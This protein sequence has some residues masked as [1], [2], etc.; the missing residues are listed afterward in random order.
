MPRRIL[1]VIDSDSYAKWGASLLA[2]LGP[3]WAVELVTVASRLAASDAQLAFALAGTGFRP[4]AAPRASLQQIVDRLSLEGHDAVFVSTSGA[5]AEAVITEIT[6]RVKPR[7]VIMTGLPG[8]S[9]PAKYKGLFRRAQADLFVLHSH[10]EIREY[11]ELS[12]RRGI[13]H[14]FVLATL[15]FLEQREAVPEWTGE[16]DSIVFAAQP[17]VPHAIAERR[18]VVGWLVQAARTH[19]DL[20]V[21]IKVR[22]QAGERQTHRERHPYA[23]LV[24]PDAPSNLVVEGGSMLAHLARA[25]GFVTVSSTA[26]I[27]A[28]AAD[29]PSLVLTDFGVSGDLINEVFVGS[30]LLGPSRDLVAARFRQVD[31]RWRHDNYFHAASD[32][33]WQTQLAAAAE[34]RDAGILPARPA[35]RRSRGGALRRAWDRKRA[36]GSYDHT[37]LGY[38]AATVGYPVLSARR[39][40]A[41]MR[42]RAAAA[43]VIDARAENDEDVTAPVARG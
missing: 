5:V 15:P 6:Q 22:A 18:A 9:T 19:P 41:S 29:V 32:N 43:P 27:E 23:E 26:A 11:Q 16:R 21:V 17:G 28:I 7:P 13:A 39:A 8:I 38:L 37:P 33:D 30:G 35:K 3:E 2:Q 1:G 10:R 42:S 14:N 31:P 36:F 40:L 4:D 25:V 34:L 12:T 20:R 24:P